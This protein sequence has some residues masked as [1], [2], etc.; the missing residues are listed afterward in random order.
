[1]RRAFAAGIAALALVLAG[2]QGCN[3]ILG[4][5]EAQPDPSLGADASSGTPSCTDYCNTMATNCAGNHAEWVTPQVCMAFCMTWDLGTLA[6]TVGNT[7]GCRLTHAKLAA[8]M[9]AECAKAGPAGGGVCGEQCT[10]FCP[11]DDFFC[12]MQSPKPYPGILEC[13]AACRMYPLVDQNIVNA[14]TGNSLQ[15]RFYHL[16]AAV[17]GNSSSSLSFH[18]PHTAPVSST[19]L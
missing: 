3:G 8:T 11:L 2:T 10:N 18:C 14:T 19:C 12:N 16:E 7:V 6:D 17:E 13:I 9:A 5:N 15:C 1:M 4:I